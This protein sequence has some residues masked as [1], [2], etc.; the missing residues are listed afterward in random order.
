MRKSLLTTLAFILILLPALASATGKIRI[1]HKNKTIS[2]AESALEKHLNHGDSIGPCPEQEE[3]EP[4]EPEVSEPDPS[5]GKGK[6]R[7]CHKN[8]TISVAEA[9]LEKHLNHGDSIGPCPEQ[10]E[11]EPIGLR[12]GPQYSPNTGDKE[13]DITLIQIN[14]IAVG[15]LNQY[16]NDLSLAFNIPQKRVSRLI[17]NERIQPADVFMIL[18]TA[19]L[20]G[21]PHRK[22]L[23][24]YKQHRIKGWRAV[25][26]SLGFKPGSKMFLLIK[27]DIPQIIWNYTIIEE[28]RSSWKKGSKRKRGSK[29][30]KGS[31]RKGSK[32]KGSKR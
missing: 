27:Q 30:K 10:E 8:K 19:R 12:Q 3:P 29:G 6:I 31:K 15:R 1:C 11:P 26:K 18:Q 32:R 25:V 9:A 20:S 13:F 4:E 16:I 23:S 22:L 5:T 2:V 14:Y 24:R 17:Y 21:Q 28:N 7:V